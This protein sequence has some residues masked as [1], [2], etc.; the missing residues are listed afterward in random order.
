MITAHPGAPHRGGLVPTMNNIDWICPTCGVPVRYEAK[1]CP[2]CQTTI[3]GEVP[4]SWLAAAAGYAGLA[5]VVCMGWTA[6]FALCGL[7]CALVTGDWGFMGAITVFGLIAGVLFGVGSI[8]IRAFGIRL[9]PGERQPN[10]AAHATLLGGH[11]LGALVPILKPF[12]LVIAAVVWL[13]TKDFKGQAAGRGR[14]A[15]LGPV[16]LGLLG[17]G[18]LTFVYLLIGPPPPGGLKLWE[19][20]VGIFVLAAIGAVLGLLSDAW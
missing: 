14:R 3:D 11:V 10:H 4:P 7:I 1:A 9:E 18:M 16:V 6:F 2:F 17:V 12:T 15:L 8:I 20:V 13:V 19:A 5:L